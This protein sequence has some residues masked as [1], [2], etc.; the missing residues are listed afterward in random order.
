MRIVA[1]VMICWILALT[2]DGANGMDLTI[3]SMPEGYHLITADDCGAPD[4]QPHVFGD[5]THTFSA[6]NVPA[7]ESVRSVAWG[8]T[9]VIA[10]YE[11]LRANTEYALA[12]TYANEPYNNRIQSLYAGETLLHGPR[13]LPRGGY[14]RTLVRVPSN[15]ITNGR[16]ELTFRLEGQVNVVVSRIELWGPYTVP[17]VLHL[18]DISAL[19]KDV[20]GAVYDGAWEPVGGVEVTLSAANRVLS[21]TVTDQSGKFRYARSILDN[22]PRDEAL[23]LV[24]ATRQAR[25]ELRLAPEDVWFEPTRYRPVPSRVTGLS[26]C[27]RRL[28]GSWRIRTDDPLRARSSP[29]ND[30]GWRLFRVPGQWLQQGIDVPM[31]HPVSVAREFILPAAWKGKR[32]ILRFDAVHAGTRYYM[33]GHL[34]GSSE[35]LF[36]PVEWDITDHVVRDKPN[37]LDMEM[38]VQTESERLSHAS[39]YAFHNLGGIPRAVCLY[40]LPSTYI[41]ALRIRAGLTHAY[42]RGT[43]DVDAEISGPATESSEIRVSVPGETGNVHTP[44]AVGAQSVS[45]VYPNIRPWTPETPHRYTVLVELLIDGKVQERIERKIGF[46]SVERS[47]SQVLVNGRS[48]KLAGACR[49]EIDPLTGRADTARWAET[50][51]RLLKEANLNYIRTAHYPPTEEFLDE[52]D[53]QG[54]FVEVEAPFCWVGNESYSSL[55]PILTPTAAMVDYHHMHPSVIIWSL[56]NESAFNPCFEVSNQLVKDLDPT[57]LTTFNNPDPKRICDIANVHY[58]KMPFDD[59]DK[60][61]PRPLLLGEYFFPVCHEQ[62]DVRRNPGLRELWGAGHSEPES[63]YARTIAA[64]F[65]WPYMQPGEPPG[66]WTHIVRSKRL[67]GG[68]IWAALDEPFYLPGG[69]QAGYA[70]VHGFWGIIDGWRRPKPESWLS[71]SIFSPVWFPVRHLGI[72]PGQKELTVPVENRFAFTNLSDLTF[73]VWHRNRRMTLR[74]AAEPGQSSALTIPL[75]PDAAAG[76]PIVVEPKTATGMSIVSATLWLGPPALGKAQPQAIHRT[77]GLQRD[78]APGW[79]PTFHATRFDFADL[80]PERAPFA[81]LPTGPVHRNQTAAPGACL[82]TEQSDDFSGDI[83]M[84]RDPDGRWKISYDVV[85]TG[86]DVYL[87]EIGLRFG[88]PGQDWVLS[89][90]RWSEW[91]DAPED[92]IMRRIGSAKPWRGR[93]RSSRPE[94][95]R[96]NNAWSLDE[97][98][99]GTADFRSVK[100]NV[101]SASLVGSRGRG[102]IVH[103]AADVHVRAAIEGTETGFYLLTRC[104]IG[105]QLVRQGE[106]LTG[107]FVIDIARGR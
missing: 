94:S 9:R 68:A 85:R 83:R 69:K 57:R 30:P 10:R 46:R 42:T 84:I 23:T 2:I 18:T 12:I 98:E 76:E 34:I 17:P 7:P 62:T 33:N 93:H 81:V 89:W 1:T 8:R 3:P 41:R 22:L 90:E 38:I 82:L 56:A 72:A 58:P 91:G 6:E 16:L 53:R 79:T 75:P 14:E 48:I 5:G 97:T 96:P 4:R 107:G 88:L 73:E 92:T 100:L 29:L 86:P 36:T 101:L 60:D 99:E 21:S 78:D 49:H 43:L 25:A 24:A 71:R 106:R 64:D 20:E 55:R 26:S 37:R 28:D 54:I 103:G 66:T 87:R 105:P 74:C 61:D 27:T 19:W 50:D 63:A 77:S 104:G 40:A 95:V 11:S 32:I 80:W 51:V 102:I 15:A 31:E 45:M 39:G 65:D 13:A 44:L 52:C 70:W 59:Y 35:N 47:G 67:L